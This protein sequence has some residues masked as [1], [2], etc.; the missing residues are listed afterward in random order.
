MSRID[1][2]I[3]NYQRFAQLPWPSG[4]APAQRIWMAVYSPED[5]RR[6][7]LHLPEFETASKAA[8]HDWARIDISN[9]FEEWMAAHEYRDAYFA[10][11]KLIQPELAGFLDQLVADVRRQLTEF[12]TPNTI[13]GLLGTGSLFGLGE[14]VKV[15][16]LVSRIEELVQGRLLVFFPGEVDQNNYRLLNGRDGW[17]YHAVPITADK[18]IIL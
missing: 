13:I 14:Q 18:G 1:D 12:S 16:A 5:E 3:A 9:S 7:R 2:L 17:N 6:L 4:L 15:S 11:P 10:N 8:G